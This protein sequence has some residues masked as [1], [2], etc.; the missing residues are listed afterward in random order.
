M[1]TERPDNDEIIRV[2]NHQLAAHFDDY[3]TLVKGAA[4]ADKSEHEMTLRQAFRVHKKAV[5]WSM[6]LSAALIMEGYDVVV[7]S[8]FYR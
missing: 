1:T 5:M 6:I 3:A 4:A 8:E 2:D 7:V